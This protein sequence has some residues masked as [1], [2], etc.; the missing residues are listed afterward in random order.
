MTTGVLFLA[1]NGFIDRYDSDSIVL[2]Y[3]IIAITRNVDRKQLFLTFCD[4]T[5]KFHP[6]KKTRSDS[7]QVTCA[8][9]LRQ[10][11]G[12]HGLGA[13]VSFFISVKVKLK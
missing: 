2:W 9:H 7:R 13:G 8:Y 1:D 10:S 11:A 5:C 4:Y 12:M 6:N 3:A